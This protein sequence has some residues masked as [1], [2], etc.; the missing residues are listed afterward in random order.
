MVTTRKS[1]IA[2]VG[3]ALNILY[4]FQY[5]KND[6]E[7]LNIFFKLLSYKLHKLNKEEQYTVVTCIAKE[8]QEFYESVV[9]YDWCVKNGDIICSSDCIY[10]CDADIVHYYK[11]KNNKQE[12]NNK[13]D[14][15][16]RGNN[17]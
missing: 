3:S 7:A 12:D 10:V 14:E 6:T 16:H 1:F 8:S 9:F 2:K 17:G 13:K 4:E 5:V 15:F 11:S